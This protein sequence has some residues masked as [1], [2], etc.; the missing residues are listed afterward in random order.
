MPIIY[1]SLNNATF[2]ELDSSLLLTIGNGITQTGGTYVASPNGIGLAT[3]DNWVG[4]LGSPDPNDIVSYHTTIPTGGIGGTLG[5]IQ[6]T[7]T[8]ADGA[9]NPATGGVGAEIIGWNPT[10]VLLEQLTGYVPGANPTITP[11]GSFLI[12]TA[13][14]VDLSTTDGGPGATTAQL[15]FG[16]TGNFPTFSAVPEPSTVLLMPLLIV[17]LLV[18]RIPAVRS[19]L[20]G[21]RSFAGAR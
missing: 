19:F 10:G 15:T 8:Q 6:Y 20:G 12:L 16:T 9:I 11:D 3:Y 14:S 7:F 21:C 5:I 2:D 17:A 4:V 13:P 1:S 18:A